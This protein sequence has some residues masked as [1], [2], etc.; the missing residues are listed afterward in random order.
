MAHKVLVSGCSFTK[1]LYQETWVNYLTKACND[2]EI[3]NVAARGAGIDFITYRLLHQCFHNKPDL[4]VV[5]F[6]SIDRFDWYL[7]PTNP[8]RSKAVS[9]ASWQNGKL[10]TLIN[11]DGTLSV[12]NGFCLSGGEHRGDKSYWYKYYYSE[13]AAR[14]NY[15]SKI[16]FLQN[17][18]EN[19]K[20]QYC[21]SLVY[22]LDDQV[23]QSCNK[24]Q[25][26]QDL[27]WLY[28]QINWKNFALY[29][30]IHGFK[31]YCEQKN[32]PII[33]NYPVSAA[34]QC[35]TNEVLLPVLIKLIPDLV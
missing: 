19:Q 5:L 32:F 11:P 23:E 12:N 31:N 7:D 1:D 28:Q 4:V 14:L 25:K 17:Y 26:Y 20:I 15:L 22:S 29:N 18:F 13:D 6:P 3:T 30:G 2:V 27:D 33:K 21:F 10:P 24:T 9:I 16:I 8:C 35:W 34:H